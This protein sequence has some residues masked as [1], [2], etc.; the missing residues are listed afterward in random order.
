MIEQ[1]PDGLDRQR[2]ELALQ[3]AIGQVSI[4]TKGFAAPDTGTAYA[5]L[6]SSA[7]DWVTF[8]NFFLRSMADQY[9]ISNVE[10]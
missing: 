1:I 3:L 2:R 6:A 4:A 5:G 8:R 10:S 7:P 9:S